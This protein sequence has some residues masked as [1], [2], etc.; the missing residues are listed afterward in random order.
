MHDCRRDHWKPPC[1]TWQSKNSVCE[2]RTPKRLLRNSRLQ[3]IHP[4]SLQKLHVFSANSNVV[5]RG[6]RRPSGRLRAEFK[7]V[8]ARL[9]ATRNIHLMTA[10]AGGHV[11]SRVQDPTDAAIGRQLPGNEISL[12]SRRVALYHRRSSANRGG[13]ILV[14]QGWRCRRV[15]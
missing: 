13:G 10:A 12:R 14:E 9:S 1:I 15:R 8:S 6:H 4:S 7:L 3:D 2:K 5:W 11:K